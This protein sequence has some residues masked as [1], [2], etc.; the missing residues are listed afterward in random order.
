L[1]WVNLTLINSWPALIL[2]GAGLVSG[3]LNA[4][5]ASEDYREKV[6]PLLE[7]K[8]FEC[9][10]PEKPK[11][12]LNLTEFTDYD[13][14]LKAPE[15]W[16]S[17]LERV[18]AYE[19][20][21]KKAG[22]LKFNEQQLLMKWLRQIPRPKVECDQLASDRTQN[23]YRGY[24][25]S[26]RLNRDEYNNT[27]RDLLGI[28]LP[29]KDLLPADG[30]GGEGFDTSGN[31]LFTSTIHI[32]KYLT[33][34]ERALATVLPD[35]TNGLPNNIMRAR[36]QILSPGE[37]SQ[38]R[39]RM[40]AERVLAT[41]A[42]HAFRRPVTGQEVDRWLTMF[43]RAWVRGDGYIASLRLALQAVLVSPHFLFLVEPEP[44]TSGILALAPVP[45]ASRLSY[46]L[47]SSMPDE[48]LLSVA[49]SGKL[50]ETEVYRQQ[51][52]RML[53]D[54]RAKALGERFALQW[55]D[56]ERLGTEVRPDPTQFPQF[57]A[58]LSAA[59]RAEVIAYFNF[60]V[61]GG[62]SLLEL[63]DS[64]YTFV[65][66]RL[67]RHYGFSLPKHA[68]PGRGTAEMQRVALTNH[69]RGGVLG[70]AAVH[71]VSSFPLRTSPVLRGKWVLE[72]LLGDRVPPP[73]PDTPT[74]PA[75]SE[76][77]SQ[78]TLR[79]QLESHRSKAECAACHDRM[80]PLGFGL[81]N[82]DVLGRWRDSDGGQPVDAT[83]TMPSGETFSG[84][85]GLKK[86]LQDRKDTVMRHLIRKMAGFA[87]GREL[88]KFDECVVDQTLT[89]LKA[90]GYRST[91]LIEQIATSFPFLHRFYPK[92]DT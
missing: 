74:L 7:R 87:L 72:S 21:P 60:V 43:D 82:F 45:L 10:G 77:V 27:L 70:M 59:M 26:R 25:M 37:R 4:A 40:A 49:E 51:I 2:A 62:R 9:H 33:A 91:I 57:D 83:G 90:D 39:P 14:V 23:F 47:W 34:A 84:P 19:M 65:N 66:G 50:S 56:L 92:T 18:Q 52:Q 46:F 24:V 80:D 53:R 16:H 79:K 81:E 64:D 75:N 20:P 12:D 8:C 48:E 85:I 55:L 36:A 61:A 78:V 11:G 67:A 22:E 1:Q 28:E 17:V 31:A 13:T 35:Q 29:L 71:A 73:P 54:P 42:R 44:K 30:G 63:I 68:A 89:A 32:E 5:E 41:F 58:E 3:R 69:A 86:I 76:S 88:N 15:I 38:Q 6:R